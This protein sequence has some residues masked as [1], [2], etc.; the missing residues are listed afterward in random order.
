[1]RT[2]G[3]KKV[4]CRCNINTH[5]MGKIIQSRVRKKKSEIITVCLRRKKKRGNYM[6]SIGNALK[7]RDA[8]RLK[9]KG[10]EKDI[11]VNTPTRKLER[12][13]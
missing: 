10:S 5:I 11:Y 9:V 4:K 6:L 8:K 12:L 1:M 13:S 7:F 3:E 2:V